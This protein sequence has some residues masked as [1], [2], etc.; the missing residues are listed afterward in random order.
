[1]LNPLRMGDRST[2]RILVG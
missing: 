1:M 2:C